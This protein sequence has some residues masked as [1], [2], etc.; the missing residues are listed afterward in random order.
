MLKG[1]DINK[2]A[3]KTCVNSYLVVYL[4]KRKAI[5]LR[6]TSQLKTADTKTN[7]YE[8]TIKQY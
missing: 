5:K 2:S 6:K 7:H 1:W 3:V 4:H 8:S